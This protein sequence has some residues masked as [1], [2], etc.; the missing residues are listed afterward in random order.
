MVDMM[1]SAENGFRHDLPALR[2]ALWLCCCAWSA[3]TDRA[4]RAPAI[5]VLDL[6]RQ[7]HPQ[8]ALIEDQ[9]VVE[10]FGP[11]RFHPALGDG[12]SLR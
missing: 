9:H 1:Q 11:Q 10:T 8:M 5:E 7:Y 4:M 3:L 6:F 2:T 12:V